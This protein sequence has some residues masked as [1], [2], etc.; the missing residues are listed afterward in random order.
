MEETDLED[1]VRRLLE[2]ANDSLYTNE[3]DRLKVSLRQI[4]EVLADRKAGTQALKQK[5]NALEARIVPEVSS[6][7]PD[8]EHARLLPNSVPGFVAKKD[9]LH[10]DKQFV[11][12]LKRN[13]DWAHDKCTVQW[14]PTISGRDQWMKPGRQ[15]LVQGQDEAVQTRLI[16]SARSSC[17]F[18]IRKTLLDGAV[19]QALDVNGWSV[20][21]HVHH[22]S[23]K[24]FSAVLEYIQ[25]AGGGESETYAQ[26]N[27]G[28]RS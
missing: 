12:D 18:C 10:N 1:N 21:D 7:K 11:P 27:H 8:E 22:N 2:E 20:W 15:H 9:A 4:E 19:V 16:A 25:D 17:L 23:G 13:L 3:Q 24:N 6:N 5:R 14:G 26:E 28:G